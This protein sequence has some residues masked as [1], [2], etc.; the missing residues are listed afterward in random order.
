MIVDRPLG[1]EDQQV[2]EGGPPAQSPGLQGRRLGLQQEGAAGGQLEVEEPRREQDFQRLPADGAAGAVVQ[3]VLQGHAALP[4]GRAG[5]RS[6]FARRPGGSRGGSRRIAARRILRDDA[7]RLQG[8]DEGQ[9]G[10]VAAGHFRGVDPDFAVV[11]LQAGQGRHDVLDHVHAGRARVAAPCAAGVSMRWATVAGI[12]GQPGKSPR[13]KTIP[14]SA[15][16]RAELDAD[17]AP[18][19]V[20]DA[21]DRGR[22]GYRSLSPCHVH[23]KKPVI[24]D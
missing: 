11:D 2:A 1:A 4:D 9:A 24:H 5:P 8:R 3:L 18:A 19:P 20:A 17:V 7:G 15:A 6:S 16:R 13:T 23:P 12:R 10:A 14:V 22:G 21:F